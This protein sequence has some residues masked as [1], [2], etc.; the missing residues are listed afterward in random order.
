MYAM[1]TSCVEVIQ[2]A[3]IVSVLYFMMTGPLGQAYCNL[4]LDQNLDQDDEN[5]IWSSTIIIVVFKHNNTFKVIYTYH[6]TRSSTKLV[7]KIIVYVVGHPRGFDLL[8]I[9][10]TRWHLKVLKVC[11]LVDFLLN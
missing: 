2:D 10:L 6:G 7:Y 3:I 1:I 8:T 4:E 5:K 11:L 9:L